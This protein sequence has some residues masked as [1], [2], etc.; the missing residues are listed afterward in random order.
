MKRRSFLKFGT[1]GAVVAGAVPWLPQLARAAE[2]VEPW[3]L[4]GGA[5]ESAVLEALPGKV[6][7][8]KRSYRPPNFETP[9][10][11]FKEEFTPNNA[12]FVRYHL[13]TIPEVSASAWRVQIGG[14]AAGKPLELGFEDLKSGYEQVEL[15]AV[16]LCSGNRRGLFQPHVAGVEWGIGAMGNARWKGVRLR[17]VLNK[18]GIRKDAVEIVL[19]GADGAVFPKTPDFVKSLPVWKAM[20]E[21]TLLAWEMN[22]EPLPH[23]NGFPVR[24]VVPGWT[25]TYWMKH[26]TSIMAEAKPFSGFWMNPA[27]R[28]P[29]GK[30]PVVDRFITQET[31]VNTPIT[32]MV[33]NSLITV[34]PN[35]GRVSAGQTV[36]IG[37]IAWDGGYG[38]RQVEV[39]V[40]GGATWR[41]AE[42][43]RDH[44]RFS[45][46]QWS[47]RFT[48]E[49]GRVTVMAKATNR[50]GATQTFELIHNPAGYHHNVVH[51][52]TLEAA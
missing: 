44:G 48:P 26:V 25:G 36:S 27:Y 18:A 7:L 11:Y 45:F 15:A 16:C 5:V 42:L 49:R 21:N 30:F 20:D 28:I 37:G 1:G 19:N 24:V 38:V 31:A 8:I 43:G 29:V 51:K 2:P 12:F 41:N 39:S 3:S 40:D 4:P 23:W 34:V 10:E 6:P 13:A 35:G 52:V 46:R 22:G 47:Y 33:V 14:A 50:V 9:I 17:D 32:E